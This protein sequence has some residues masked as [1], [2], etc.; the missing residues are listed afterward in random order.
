MVW[1][2]PVTLEKH[3]RDIL[4]RFCAEWVNLRS[5]LDDL[6]LGT[7]IKQPIGESFDRTESAL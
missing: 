6:L 7:P 1:Y 3:R 4:T 2:R 5:K